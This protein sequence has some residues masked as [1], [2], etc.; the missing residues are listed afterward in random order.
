MVH[1]QRW[2][3]V[4]SDLNLR[5]IFKNY[6]FQSH[7]N[8]KSSKFRSKRKW[9]ASAGCKFCSIEQCWGAGLRKINSEFKRTRSTTNVLFCYS[10]CYSIR[11]KW[12]CGV[13][14]QSRT[15]ETMLFH[16]PWLVPLVSDRSVWQMERTLGFLM[17]RTCIV[18][19]INHL[20][21]SPSGKYEVIFWT[22]D[23]EL[24]HWKTFNTRQ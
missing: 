21:L 5:S 14:L 20:V 23:T 8:T 16:F 17:Y 6:R 4:R 18:L 15:I 11:C 22:I 7:F 12:V 13:F 19:K 10:F 3:S 2:Y 1:L 24:D 9:N